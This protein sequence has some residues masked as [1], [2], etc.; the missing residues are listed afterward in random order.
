LPLL[1]LMEYLL[2]DSDTMNGIFA[3]ATNQERLQSC[4]VAFWTQV[5]AIFN[6]LRPLNLTPSSIGSPTLHLKEYE[7]FRGFAPFAPFL[8]DTN[9][10]EA[11][12]LLDDA[13]A[14]ERF[15]VEDGK[16]GPSQE[17]TRPSQASGGAGTDESVHVVKIQRLLAL[18]PKVLK[19]VSNGARV[20]ENPSN[21]DLE[22][23]DVHEGADQGM[24]DD[25]DQAMDFTGNDENNATTPPTKDVDM[26]DDTKQNDIL[27]YQQCERG[28]PALLVPGAL[29]SSRPVESLLQS[30]HQSALDLAAPIG[31]TRAIASATSQQQAI[32]ASI[33]AP[34][35]SVPPLDNPQVGFV[36]LPPPG[37]A[38]Q[39][40]QQDDPM[41]FL[42]GNMQQLAPDDSQTAPGF[43]SNL[44]LTGAALAP[45]YGPTIGESLLLFGGPTALQ[46]ANPFATES[47]P[48]FGMGSSFAFPQSDA[49]FLVN[50]DAMGLDGTSL[51]DS[52]LLSS[53]LMDDS[54][55]KAT[56]RNPFAT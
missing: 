56:T 31:S 8:N 49:A 16:N 22:V 40:Q 53:L 39:Q 20:R 52:S 1:L 25:D 26:T 6:L 54:P 13:A 45:S 41:A 32:E 4:T 42:L 14:K 9:V 55:Q 46:T 18:R 7:E 3:G 33:V 48:S 27:V 19:L 12:Y 47:L 50:Q 24:S 5:A 44:N 38:S 21:G 23:I 37:F 51:L 34:L 28:G 29:L 11:G 43:Y 15:L 2:T 17:S 10:S 30:N 36:V 35:P